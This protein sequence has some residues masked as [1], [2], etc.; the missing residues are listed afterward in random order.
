[1]PVH[2]KLNSYLRKYK[3]IRPH[4]CSICW[5]EWKKIIAHHPN[6]NE[7]YNVVFCCESCH[8]DIHE[9]FIKNINIVNVLSY[10]QQ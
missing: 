10:N 2:N 7:R 5:V 6:Y 9:N 3:H 8:R 1:V 4:K